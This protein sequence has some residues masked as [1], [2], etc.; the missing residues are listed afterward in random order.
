[1]CDGDGA[2]RARKR[3]GTVRE[4]RDGRGMCTIGG[5]TICVSIMR[6]RRTGRAIGEC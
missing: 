2:S 4:R 6:S 1:M 3:K 5:M